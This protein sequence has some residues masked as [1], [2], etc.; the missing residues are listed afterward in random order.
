MTTL[1]VVAHPDDEVLGCGGLAALL[2]GQGQTVTSC[3]LSG[4]VEA[5]QGRPELER[6]HANA[7]EAQS[8]LG[9]S[10][11]IL[12]PFPNIAFNTVPHLEL[13]QFIERVIR[14]YSA[15]RVY[16]HHPGDLNNDHRHTSIACQAAVRLFQR[17]PALPP[18][19]RLAFMEILSSTDWAFPGGG[20]SF[21]PTYFVELG[22][23]LL[24]KKLRALAVYEG[25]MRPFP[26]PRSE[27]VLRG[28]AAYRGGQAGMR[29]AEAFQV[30]FERHP[31]A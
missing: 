7:R 26:H 12:G 16:T 30:V 13:V 21:T 5:R 29:Y 18:L 22:E 1:I 11:P 19:E 8:I 24:A 17:D 27:E 3:I 23:E 31:S 2:A 6:L 9:L 15:T 20:T 28:L 4:N 25:V 10:E 14:Q